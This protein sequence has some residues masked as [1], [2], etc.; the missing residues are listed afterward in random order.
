MKSKKPNRILLLSTNFF[1]STSNLREFKIIDGDE[2]LN[3]LLC[4]TITCSCSLE[5]DHFKCVHIVIFIK[6]KD[7]CSQFLFSLQEFIL[8]KIFNQKIIKNHFDEMDMQHLEEAYFELS[9][10][11][12]CS[13]CFTPLLGLKNV[14]FFPKCGAYGHQECVK[15]CI[16]AWNRIGNNSAQY[17]HFISNMRFIS[18]Y[19]KEFPPPHLQITQKIPLSKQRPT[20]NHLLEES[21]ISKKN[22]NT[23]LSQSSKFKS[24]HSIHPHYPEPNHHASLPYSHHYPAPPTNPFYSSHHSPNPLA[25]SSFFPFA[26]PHHLPSHKFQSPNSPKHL[27]HNCAPPSH[28]RT[29]KQK[30][31]KKKKTEEEKNPHNQ[32]IF[33]EVYIDDFEDLGEF[34]EPQLMHNYENANIDPFFPISSN[35]NF[36]EE[37]IYSFSE[38]NHFPIPPFDSYSPHEDSIHHLQNYT[39]QNYGR[40]DLDS[41]FLNDSLHRMNS[42]NKFNFSNLKNPFYQS[43]ESFEDHNFDH[44]YNN[45]PNHHFYENEMKKRKFDSPFSYQISPRYSPPNNLLSHYKQ[46]SPYEIDFLHHDPKINPLKPFSPFKNGD[47]YSKQDGLKSSMESIHQP[48][49]I[50]QLSKSNDHFDKL[51][52]ENLLSHSQEKF[53]DSSPGYN[54]PNSFSFFDPTVGKDISYQLFSDVTNNK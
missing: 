28:N 12:N 4:E 3:I 8:K 9:T 18:S 41:P 11:Y 24:Y 53:P 52:F 32:K 29:Q 50:N 39:N 35:Q 46:E 17:H 33:P 14:Y 21:L 38:S 37:D 51:S 6:K 26:S 5:S 43:N 20:E 40:Q 2:I 31:E 45:K 27:A 10:P 42:P 54:N 7:L 47:I 16:S 48:N 25:S 1:E 13:I 15:S 36:L 44:H 49:H 19:E 34:E 30:H 22:F 23:P